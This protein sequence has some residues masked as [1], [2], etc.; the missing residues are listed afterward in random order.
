[1][2]IFAMISHQRLYGNISIYLCQCTPGCCICLLPKYTGQAV[3]F[4]CASNVAP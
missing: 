4:A 1:M 2:N 3:T